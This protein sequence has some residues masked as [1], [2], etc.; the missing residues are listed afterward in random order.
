MA[1]L[2]NNHGY[3]NAPWKDALSHLLPEFEIFEYPDIPDTTK[4]EY[5]VIWHHEHGDLLRYKNL[6]AIL[7]L[8]AG[9]DHIDQD[10]SLPA[11]PIIRLVDPDVGVDMA[12]YVCYFLL[13]FHR[14][15][16]RYFAQQAEA[17]WQRHKVAR[18]Q[19]FRVTVLGLGRIGRYVA[20]RIADLGYAVQAWSRTLH[21]VDRVACFSK[22]DGLREAL[23]KTHVLVNCLPLNPATEKLINSA[24]LSLMPKGAYLI[25]ISRGGVIDDRALLDALQTGQIAGAALDTFNQ[26]PLPADSPYWQ[27]DNV[28]VTPHMSGATYARSAAQ[29]IADNI[30]R[31]ENGE[32][33]FPIHKKS[34]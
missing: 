19:D 5:A 7:L 1:I 11:V 10:Q 25:N 32:Q 23:S 24:K 29:P 21:E 22:Q 16:D 17:I 13:H 15:F 4:I 27:L 12:H 2:L 6:R 14:K 3:D 18:A 20:E 34:N 8:G 9:T 31:I 28:F 26:E 33:P 30:R